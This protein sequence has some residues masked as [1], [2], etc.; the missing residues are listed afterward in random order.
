MVLGTVQLGMSYG[1]A[2]SSGRPDATTALQMLRAAEAEGLRAVDTAPT[3]GDAEDLIGRSGVKLPVFTKFVRGQDPV[4]SV[5]LSLRRLRRDRIEI[6][7]FHDPA[8]FET[9]DEKL[10][11]R[12]YSVVGSAIGALGASVYTGAQ[13][14]RAVHEERI[15]AVQAPFNLADRRLRDEGAFQAALGRRLPVYL[16]SVFLQGALLL[17]TDRLPRYLQDLRPAIEAAERVARRRQCRRAA[18]LLAFAASQP[19][20]AGVIV[21]ADTP[22]QLRANLIDARGPVLDDE[23]WEDLMSVPEAPESVVD[24]RRWPTN[25]GAAT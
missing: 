1:I 2:N 21:G 10:L 8:V 25:S 12:G 9:R 13:F 24:P 20:I 23:D 5:E 4:A 7:F 22:Q 15:G 14:M 3:Y 6:A 17:P 18:V 19:G 11:S 16:R